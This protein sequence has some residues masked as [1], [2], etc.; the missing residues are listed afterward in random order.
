MILPQF[1]YHKVQSVAGAIALYRKYKGKARYCAGGTDLIPLLKQRL[2]AP[3]A[4]I[5]L[6]GIDE[7]KTITRRKGV[8]I[9]GANVTLFDL[10]ND[11]I[12]REHF[13]AL[14]QSLDA[15]SCETLQMRGTIGGNILQDTRCIQYNKSLEWRT[16]R[17]FCFKMGGKAC[18][19]V[20]NAQACFSNYCSDNA[21]A[22][23]TLSAKVRLKGLKGERTVDL[24]KIFSGN[25]K[26]PFTVEPGEVL[27]A[28]LIPLKKTEGV[29]EKLRVRDSM[30][31]PLVDAAVSMAG[32]K[33]R[34]CIGGIGP[35]PRLYV[36]KNMDENTI[37]DTADKAYADAKP[38]ANTTISAAYRKKMVSTLVKRA[39]KRVLKE[40]GR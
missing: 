34:V 31:Y 12:V 14:F 30:D 40:G 23:I 10:K 32:G 2:S 27:T 16:S 3:A 36:I 21:P 39:I 8:L 9:I 17:G 25:G 29:Y 20:L 33:A 13:P 6:K 37:R 5:D 18:N 28:I 11:P 22:L 38:V 7:L 26:A 19:V 24:E 15:T 35:A 1:E 4:V